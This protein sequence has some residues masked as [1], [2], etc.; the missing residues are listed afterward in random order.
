MVASI[1]NLFLNGYILFFYSVILF[2]DNYWKEN[3][4]VDDRVADRVGGVTVANRVVATAA[5][6]NTY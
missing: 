4:T 1:F 6:R 3:H 5:P 2:T